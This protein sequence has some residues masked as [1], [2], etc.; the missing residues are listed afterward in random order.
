M[1]KLAVGALGAMGEV[2]SCTGALPCLSQ[3]RYS[4]PATSV[5]ALA[6]R[7]PTRLR[8]HH[9][10]PEE[11]TPSQNRS[12][13]GPGN[14]KHRTIK[15]PPAHVSDGRRLRCVLPCDGHECDE[16]GYLLFAYAPQ[17][18]LRSRTITMS[19]EGI[20]DDN[21]LCYCSPVPGTLTNPDVPQLC[22]WSLLDCG[23]C[24]DRLG[25]DVRLHY[26]GWCHLCLT[27]AGL[28]CHSSQ[29]PK[30]PSLPKPAKRPFVLVKY[31]YLPSLTPG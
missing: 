7:E 19:L 4:W 10:P 29:P 18:G 22:C 3:R 12:R 21:G 15:L 2:R 1:R 30:G 9:P 20:E 14:Q 24:V 5:C 25:I 31:D 6:C 13:L 17:S 27:G 16:A 23:I 26:C 8:N 28:F 11:Q